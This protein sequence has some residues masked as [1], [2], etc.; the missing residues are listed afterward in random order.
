MY[1]GIEPGSALIVEDCGIEL[2]L[3]PAAVLEVEW[4]HHLQQ[5][6]NLAEALLDFQGPADL[7]A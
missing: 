4:A 5:L 7:A 3:K 6:E 1:M 2:L